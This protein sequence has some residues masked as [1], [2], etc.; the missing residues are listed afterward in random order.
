MGSVSF[1]FKRPPGLSQSQWRVLSGQAELVV[2]NETPVDTTRLRRSWSEPDITRRALRMKTDQTSVDYASVVNEG[3]TDR[4]LSAKEAAN[5]GF[6]ERAEVKL[7]E[8][9]KVL[10][11]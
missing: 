5:K 8:L 7:S 9:A 11:R 10:T 1:L 2:R 3:R 6:V 4:P